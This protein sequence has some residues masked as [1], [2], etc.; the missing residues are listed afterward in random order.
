MSNSNP[1]SIFRPSAKSVLA[2]FFI[3]LAQC[4]LCFAFI[5]VI[6]TDRVVRLLTS[7]AFYD[8]NRAEGVLVE[9]TVS[10][11]VIS[12]VLVFLIGLL[13]AFMLT[14]Y[15]EPGSARKYTFMKLIAFVT[16]V[17]SCAASHLIISAMRM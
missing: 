1:G 5:G 12:S 11:S 2:T 9:S 10:S 7:S 15:Q 4:L 13:T 14:R 16:L 6:A 3:S 8:G 17:A